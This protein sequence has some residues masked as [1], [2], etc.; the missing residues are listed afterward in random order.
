MK[1]C[2]HCNGHLTKSDKRQFQL[3]K[4]LLPNEVGNMGIKFLYLMLCDRCGLMEVHHEN[5]GYIGTYGAMLDRFW[6][7]LFRSGK[8]V[9]GEQAVAL[10]HDQG[11]GAFI[12]CDRFMKEF[13]FYRTHWAKYDAPKPKEKNPDQ[14]ELVF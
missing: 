14:N 8:V 6:N 3:K 1:N 9:C 4:W 11:Y 12:S 7:S 10:Y 5:Q 2:N 13:A